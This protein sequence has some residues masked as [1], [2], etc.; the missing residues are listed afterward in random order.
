[1]AIK[2]AHGSYTGNATDNRDITGMGFQPKMVVIKDAG[3]GAGASGIATWRDADYSWYFGDNTTPFANYIQDLATDG[4]QV[5]TGGEVNTTGR[6]YYWFALGG[7]DTDIKVGSYSGNG[8]DNR[9]I[10]GV[11]FQPEVLFVRGSGNRLGAERLGGIAG[12]ASF[13]MGTDQVSTNKIQ[14]LDA[15]GFTI[16]TNTYVNASGDTYYYIAIKSVANNFYTGTY[17]GNGTDNRD[18]TSPGFQPE[19]VYI[20][21]DIVGYHSVFRTGTHVG[22]DTSMLNQTANTT[23]QIQAINTDG[24]EVSDQTRVNESGFNFYYF[25]AKTN[26]AASVNSG[27]LMFM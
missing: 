26:S 13:T 15:D 3:A 24:F 10:T 4:F 17:A 14:S 8:T 9:G 2:V 22:D 5:G 27:F 20:M 6:T 16:G 11:G 7:D 21:G 18:I 19:L 25:A 12:D 1:M 23:N